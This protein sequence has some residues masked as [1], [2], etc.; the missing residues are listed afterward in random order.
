MARLGSRLLVQQL[1]TQSDRIFLDVTIDWRLLAFTA[2]VGALACAVFGLAPALRSSHIEPG[3]AIKTGG[4]GLTADRER[5]SF[6]RLLVVGQFSVSLVLV[7]GALLFVRSFRNLMT[8]DLGFRH[9]GILVAFFNMSRLGLPRADTTRIKSF[10]QE[11]LG[12]VR[13]IPQVEA[14]ATTTHI[15]IGGGS[16]GHGIRA[17]AVEGSSKF[18]WVSPGFLDTLQIPLLAGRDFNAGDTEASPK[19]ALVN[20]AFVRHFFPNA[21]PLGKTFRT[22]PEPNYPETV[23]QIIGVI[24]DTKYFDVRDKAPATSYAPGSQF[25]AKGPWSMMYIRSSAPLGPLAAAMRRRL[26]ESHSQ[27]G[28]EFRVFQTQIEEGLIRERLMAALSGFFGAL[29]A[30]L[31]TIGLYGVMAYVMVRRRNEIGIRMALGASRP[32]IVG[33]VMKQAA[34]LLLI[35][36]AIGVAG[37]LLFASA[38][39]KLLFGLKPR[40]PLTFLAATALLAAVGALGSYLPAQRASRLDPMIA[41]RDE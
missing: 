18:T 37:S 4:R 15:L 38:A 2:L 16:W 22:S 35:G 13:S 41:L 7:V 30:L 26:G 8:V 11:L 21:D 29:A 14:A 19:V 33:L 27:M 17:G 36:V 5:F 39:G 40:D 32:Q 25:P 10:E 20:Q 12:E 1:S 6:Q 3:S 31:A 23:Y 24:K 9:K 28:M 34:F